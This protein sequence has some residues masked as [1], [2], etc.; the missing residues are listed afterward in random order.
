MSSNLLVIWLSEIKA[1]I[2][3]IFAHVFPEYPEIGVAVVVIS[4]GTFLYYVLRGRFHAAPKMA[5]SIFAC[6]VFL[7]YALHWLAKLYR[8]AF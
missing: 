7:F 8:V 4:L 5:L 3:V 1:W 2:T 6:L